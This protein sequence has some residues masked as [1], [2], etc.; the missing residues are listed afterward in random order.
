MQEIP[1]QKFRQILRNFE[2][3]LNTQNQSGC[4]CGVSITQCHTLMALDQKDNITLNELAELV[5][6][7][8]STVS[9][10]VDTLVKSGLIDRTIQ[11]SNR[12]TT[13]I[14]LTQKG[15]EEC[16]TI[17]SGNNRYYRQ[18]LAALPP[19]LLDPFLKGFEMLA[20]AMSLQN[21]STR[22]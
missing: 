21:D 2:R 15:K 7:D 13:L 17:N 14:T 6:L 9:R 20:I 1:V 3:E 4:C 16:H 18:V 19:D 10:T 8:K 11:E 22:S 5:C 12:R